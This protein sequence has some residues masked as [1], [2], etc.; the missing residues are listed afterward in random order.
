MPDAAILPRSICK[1]V[2]LPKGQI[3]VRKA[4]PLSF[5]QFWA[6]VNFKLDE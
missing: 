1:P 3:A 6:I 5:C 4:Y 2:A